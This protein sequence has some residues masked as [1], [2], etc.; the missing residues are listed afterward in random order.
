MKQFT[1]VALQQDMHQHMPCPPQLSEARFSR[2][3][4]DHT[5]SVPDCPAIHPQLTAL[6]RVSFAEHLNGCGHLLLTDTLVFL[7]LGG[8]LEALPGQRA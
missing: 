6:T 7:A 2:A 4:A 8:S 5:A 1:A 3:P